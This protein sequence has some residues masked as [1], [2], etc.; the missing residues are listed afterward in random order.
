[1]SAL[2]TIPEADLFAELRRRSGAR[3]RGECPGCGSTSARRDC[4]DPEHGTAIK[5]AA[6]KDRNMAREWGL[7]PAIAEPWRVAA[8][9]ARLD[10]LG[11]YGFELRPEGRPLQLFVILTANVERDGRR[12]L[13]VSASRSGRMPTYLDLVEVK[14]VFIGPDR[15]AY[16]VFPRESEHYNAHTFCL[17]LWCCVDGDALPDLRHPG[18]GV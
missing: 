18:G 16:Q 10:L 8:N 2:V 14:R 12:W 13:H 11:H 5:S 7:L 17:H 1:M 15:T 9:Q 3:T 4:G 6:Q